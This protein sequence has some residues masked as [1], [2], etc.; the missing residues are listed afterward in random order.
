M[1]H[2]TEDLLAAWRSAARDWERGRRDRPA[3]TRLA[4]SWLEYQAAVGGI[5]E[6]ELVLIADDDGN[7]VGATPNAERYLGIALDSVLALT[8]A[9]VTAPRDR[10]KTQRAWAAFRAAG[11][12][13][14]TFRLWR[15]DGQEVPAEFHARANVPAPGLHVSRLTPSPAWTS[16]ADVATAAAKATARAKG[17]IVETRDLLHGLRGSPPKAL[18][19]LRPARRDAE[20]GD[21]P[22]PAP[23]DLPRTG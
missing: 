20:R 11:A 9:G 7:Y 19:T 2:E 17:A 8:I 18:S 21:G 4:S 13:S 1:S 10:A 15:R 12:A 3:A 6:T 5:A 16:R 22:Q 23:A 14:G